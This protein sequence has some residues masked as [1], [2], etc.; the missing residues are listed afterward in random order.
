V[1]ERPEYYHD[2]AVGNA[3]LVSGGASVPG[4]QNLSSD[5]LFAE[6]YTG[7]SFQEYMVLANLS[8]SAPVSVNVMLEFTNGHIETVAETIAPLD[9]TFVD[10]NQIIANHLGHCDTTLCQSTP[11]V[12]AEVVGD[13]NFIAQ[14]EMYF[15]YDHVGNGRTLQAM[16]GTDVIGQAGPAAAMIY[17]F[18][19]GYTNVNYDEWLTLQN[20][21]M[22]PETIFVTLV[23]A[24]GRVFTQGYLVVAESRF[25]VDITGLVLQHLLVPDDT[26]RGYEVSMVVQSSD[27]PFVAERPMYW[28]IGTSGIQGGS[29][30]VG[31][32]GG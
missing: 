25:T 24:D 22:T 1:V 12:S 3:G 4:M 5:W 26:Y 19:E 7:G 29:D 16:G 14:R 32:T 13:G 20:P 9:Q 8:S 23:N 15:H 11:S 6:G 17:S 10:V 27:G 30:V 31:Y 18:A 21:T 28:N 2:V